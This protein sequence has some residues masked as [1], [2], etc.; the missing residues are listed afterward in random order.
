MKE[1][2]LVRVRGGGGSPGAGWPL[3]PRS[4]HVS[5]DQFQGSVPRA[6]PN[7]F[8]PG[9]TNLCRTVWLVAL[10]GDKQDF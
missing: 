3:A 9:G 4:P 6:K 5:L 8:F 7:K 2:E 1:L 10:I